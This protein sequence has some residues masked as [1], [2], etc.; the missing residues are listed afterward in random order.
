MDE[1][2]KSLT[3]ENATEA[4]FDTMAEAL[5]FAAAFAYNKRIQRRSIE[6]SAE[7]IPMSV[8]INGGYGTAIELLAVEAARDFEILSADRVSERILIFE[9]LAAAGIDELRAIIERERPPHFVDCVRDLVLS[10]TASSNESAK[11]D[12]ERLLEELDR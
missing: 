3:S 12:F 1:F 7:P 10:A 5:I 6:S 11:P 8:F 9:E 2:L 4:V